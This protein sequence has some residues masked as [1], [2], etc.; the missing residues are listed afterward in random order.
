MKKQTKLVSEDGKLVLN[1]KKNTEWDEYVTTY[2]Y[3]GKFLPEYYNHTDDIDDAIDTAAVTM[4]RYERSCRKV[5]SGNVTKLHAQDAYLTA[6]GKHAILIQEIWV[7][8]VHLTPETF[9]RYKWRELGP[10]GM[11]IDSGV[12]T[13]SIKKTI[14]MLNCK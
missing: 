7:E 10:D 8:S 12:E 3:E 14:E 11:S 1:T 6:D 5:F 2:K 4:D 13:N 9:V